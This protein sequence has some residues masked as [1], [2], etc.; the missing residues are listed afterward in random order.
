MKIKILWAVLLSIIFVVFL[1]YM[2]EWS[3][4]ALITERI[5]IKYV[6]S[7]FL[8]MLLAN[9]ARAFRFFALAHMGNKLS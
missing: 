1:S 8:F 9:I 4:F 5:I 6:C 3:H 2:L 7:S